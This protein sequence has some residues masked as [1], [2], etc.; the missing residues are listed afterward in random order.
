MR[1]RLA[2]ASGGTLYLPARTPA[3]YRYRSGA[4][5]VGGCCNHQLTGLYRD[6]LVRGRP[7]RLRHRRIGRTVFAKTSVP[8]SRAS[9]TYTVTA[10]CGGGNL[11]VA[12]HV[13]V[14]R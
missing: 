6:A 2:G 9:G 7:G 10:R 11:G 1:E 8:L 13:T 3:F 14:T 4:K 12:A 5:L